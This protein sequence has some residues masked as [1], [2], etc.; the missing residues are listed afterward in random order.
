MIVLGRPAL[1]LAPMDGITDA[2]MREFLG[3][4]GAFSYAVSEFVRVSSLVVPPKVFRREIP[5]LET[6]GLTASGLPV[7]VQLL[8]GDPELMALSAVNAVQAGATCVDINFGCPAPVVNR[9]DGGASLL[10]SPCRIR[11]IVSA[12]SS[13]VEAPVSAKLRLGWESIEDIHENAAMAAEGG[14]A[15]L[16]IHAR[17]R[18]AGYQPPVYWKPIGQVRA[19]LGIPVVANGD[20]WNLD[21]FKLCQEQTGCSH[22]MIGRGALA[23][24]KLSHEIAAELGIATRN[25]TPGEDWGHLFSSLIRHAGMEVKT[26]HRVKQWMALANKH[27]DFPHFDFL[28]RVKSVDE[29]LALLGQLPQDLVHGTALAELVN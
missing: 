20:I 16:T 3:G 13:A 22:F 25:G 23:N 7:Q 27:G 17:T 6:D 4:F 15:W 9:H 8:G 19:R 21:G 5:E 24:P 18:A 1:A 29:L 11:E 28:K 2:V 26:V 14:A 10:R 12:V